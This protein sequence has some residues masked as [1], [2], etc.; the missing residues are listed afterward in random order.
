MSPNKR[1]ETAQPYVQDLQPREQPRIVQASNVASSN[2]MILL[3]FVIFLVPVLVT[4]V[5]AWRLSGGRLTIVLVVVAVGAFLAGRVAVI[6]GNGDWVA[7]REVRA[8]YR[9]EERR[10]QALERL[11]ARKLMIEYQTEEYRHQ[12]RMAEIQANSM[13]H[14]LFARLRALEEGYYANGQ[15]Q[16]EGPASP[17]YVAGKSSTGR[18]LVA[19]YLLGQ[20]GGRGDDRAGGLYTPAGPPDANRVRADGRIINRV[21]WSSRGSWKGQ[22]ASDALDV[23][24]EPAPGAEPLIVEE[25]VENKVTGFYLNLDHYPTR[26]DV[27]AVLGLG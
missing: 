26:A 27:I 7:A 18:R 22:E 24:G 9:T 3:A 17:N 14:E 1:Y 25:R 13:Q 2:R 16:I 8:A 11:H 15:K 5:A 23:I 10:L 19:D 6:V 20:G 21:P 12:E 4:A